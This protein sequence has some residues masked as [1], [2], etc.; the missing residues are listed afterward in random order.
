MVCDGKPLRQRR[1]AGDLGVLRGD[2]L[3][4][5]AEEHESVDVAG[6]GEPVGVNSLVL[7]LGTCIFTSNKYNY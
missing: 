4:L 7:G 6:L 5:R 2:V 1:H 3:G